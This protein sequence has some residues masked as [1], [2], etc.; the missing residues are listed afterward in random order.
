MKKKNNQ[1]S[2]NVYI[3]VRYWIGRVSHPSHGSHGMKTSNAEIGRKR[4]EL[5][6]MNQCLRKSEKV[7][8]MM[9]LSW[10][11][12]VP[13]E[14]PYIT[15]VASS[16]T[17]APEWAWMWKSILSQ[18]CLRRHCDLI[19]NTSVT[20][21]AQESSLSKALTQI[22]LWINNMFPCLFTWCWKHWKCCICSSL[23]SLQ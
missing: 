17:I 10:L 9:F 20:N 19:T 12:S 22:S 18:K 6:K 23:T 1:N 5:L 4:Q 3:S 14:T 21:M 11:V 13:C 2:H 7:G 8:H 15:S 16:S